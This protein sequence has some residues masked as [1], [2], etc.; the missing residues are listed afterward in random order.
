MTG[1]RQLLPSFLLPDFFGQTCFKYPWTSKCE[2]CVLKT[3]YMN[4]GDDLDWS[5][6]WYLAHLPRKRPC[7]Y[8][9]PTPFPM[10]LLPGNAMA[11]SCARMALSMSAKSLQGALRLL[12]VNEHKWLYTPP[13]FNSSPPKNGGWK[14][15]LSYWEGN[16][17]GAMLNFRWVIIYDSGIIPKTWNMCQKPRRITSG[18]TIS[19]E[20]IIC[21]PEKW[22]GHT[23]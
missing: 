6:T 3:N 20:A 21:C 15:I 4:Q 14:T 1:C 17:S 10:E 18:T 19:N 16:F 9:H 7:I 5:F 13:K 23:V 2:N 12:L 8:L 11:R 22:L